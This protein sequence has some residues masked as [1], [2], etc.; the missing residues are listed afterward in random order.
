MEQGFLRVEETVTCV[1]RVH[2]RGMQLLRGSGMTELLSEAL[3]AI[4]ELTGADFGTIHTLDPETNQLRFAV[5]RM[6]PASASTGAQPL[7][8]GVARQEATLAD[9]GALTGISITSSMR[10]HAS[11]SD[12]KMYVLASWS[13]PLLSSKAESLGVVS[14]YS[15]SPQLLTEERLSVVDVLLRQVA[16][17]IEQSRAQR[18]LQRSHALE[19]G[20]RTAAEAANRRKDEFLATLAHEIRQPLWAAVLACEVAKR[21]LRSENPAAACEEISRQL[22]QIARLV[23]DLGDVS[24]IVRGSLELRRTRLDLRSVVQ[25][26]ITT[27]TPVLTAKQHEVTVALGSE[28][29]WIDADSARMG[30]VVSNLLHNAASYTPPGGHIWVTLSRDDGWVSLR[31][32]DNGVGIA[33]SEIDRIFDPFERGGQHNGSFSLGIG[34]A[35]VREV[36]TLHGGA[37]RVTSN[38]RDTGAEFVVTLPDQRTSS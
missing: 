35:I 30:Q 32:R 21:T 23:E 1:T 25:G 31:I 16:D 18:M 12:V 19:Q 38:G 37:V 22:R 27:A 9:P 15:R 26:G 10:D 34:L 6:R 20:A 5:D 8:E 24:R 7:F 13:S 14:T 33:A 29:C 2:E 28:P 4:L 36:V 11:P 17:F 3:D